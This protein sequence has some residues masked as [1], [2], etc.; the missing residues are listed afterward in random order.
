MINYVKGNLF[1]H[2]KN[3]KAEIFIPHVCNCMA[4]FGAG[5]A[6]EVKNRY[7]SVSKEYFGIFQGGLNSLEYLG[8]CSWAIEGNLFFFNMVAQELGGKRPLYYNHLASCLNQLQTII[9]NREELP[10]IHA[11]MFGSGLAGGDWK[12]IEPI[13][14]DAIV[15]PFPKIKV[16]FY[17]L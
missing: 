2:I 9:E 13:F 5:F 15:R 8:H 4:R 6:L 17:S 1:D 14:Y 16:T 12:V 7:P 3:N 11:P 10:E